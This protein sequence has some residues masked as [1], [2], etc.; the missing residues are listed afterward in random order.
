MRCMG[1]SISEIV[2]QLAFSRS[3]VYM[4]GE[5]KTVSHSINKWT[6]KRSLHRI[7]FESLQTTRVSLLNRRHWAARIA[8]AGVHGIGNE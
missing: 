1:Y 8:W 2:R 7:S 4:D 5:Q 3:K 6:V